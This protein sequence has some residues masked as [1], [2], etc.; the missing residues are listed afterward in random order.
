MDIEE[1]EADD[2]EADV[3]A[4]LVVRGDIESRVDREVEVGQEDVTV[5]KD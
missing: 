1:A 3:E 5:D 4:S 2:G